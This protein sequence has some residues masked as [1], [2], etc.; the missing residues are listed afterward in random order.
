MHFQRD[1]V[2]VRCP[3]RLFST[4][5]LLEI[6]SFGIEP[7][8]QRG[9]DDRFVRERPSVSAI[10]EGGRAGRSSSPRL[11]AR[12]CPMHRTKAASFFTIGP[13]SSR[14]RTC[15][16]EGDSLP[17]RRGEHDPS[18]GSMAIDIGRRRFMEC[19]IQCSNR[20]QELSGGAS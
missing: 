5:K 16:L 17:P 15:R 19:Q 7:P 10:P 3:P 13:P 14:S 20:L 6:F 2:L 1:I 9:I 8:L 18:R 12:N 11:R 4:L